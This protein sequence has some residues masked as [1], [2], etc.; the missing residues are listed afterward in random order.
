LAEEPMRGVLL[1]LILV[2]GFF[3]PAASASLDG[4]VESGCAPPCGPI[5][6][7]ITITLDKSR[8]VEFDADG[9]FEAVGKV[10]FYYDIDDNGYAWSPDPREEVWVNMKVA[11]APN[12]TQTTIEPTK[13]RVPIRPYDEA[14]QACTDCIRPE[15]DAP[16]MQFVYEHALKVTVQKTRDFD[17]LELKRWLK[18]DGTY[19]VTINAV[20]NDSMAGNEYV[21]KPAGLQE[22]YGV[23]EIRFT[24]PKEFVGASASQQPDANAPGLE[25]FGLLAALGAALVLVRR[26]D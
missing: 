13:F 19:R 1:S 11:K 7:I 24:A 23:K 4:A 3:A 10:Q 5:P 17:A 12:W 2:A 22:G 26:R 16:Q 6:V 14:T 18:S 9:K 20:S 8:N 15:G 25:M 21:G